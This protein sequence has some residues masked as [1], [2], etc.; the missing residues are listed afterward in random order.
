MDIKEFNEKLSSSVPTPGGGAVSAL[1]S[2]VAISLS[3]MVANLTLG[4]QKYK[5]YEDEIN[6]IVKKAEKSKNKFYELITKD[7]EAY[8]ELSRAYKISKEDS[9]RDK[10]LEESLIKA[11]SV[12]LLLLTEINDIIYVVEN[13]MLKG[14][15]NAI[16]DIAISALLFESAAKSSLINIYI[17]TKSMKD[18]NKAKELNK[19]G[20]EITNEIINITE[21]V[22]N[23]VKK[24][25]V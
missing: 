3:L 9:N 6:N 18:I 23:E 25:L 11:S 17:N 5:E 10:I 15:K 13:L 14:N 16:S 24:E 21:K 4:K 2:T 20:E 7:E 1:I 8:L 19:K 12:P 22:S